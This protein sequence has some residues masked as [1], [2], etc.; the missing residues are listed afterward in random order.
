[1]RTPEEFH[2]WHVQE[3]RT[4]DADDPDEGLYRFL[5]ALSKSTRKDFRF[6]ITLRRE[7]KSRGAIYVEGLS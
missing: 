7:N 4:L 6:G 5:T 2:K 3:I 1:L